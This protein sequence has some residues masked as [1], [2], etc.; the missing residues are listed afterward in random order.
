M[1]LRLR[2]HRARVEHRYKLM[3]LQI[4]HKNDI[5]I[6]RSVVVLLW[7]F[8]RRISDL[9]IWKYRLP[10]FKHR[11]RNW[12]LAFVFRLVDR[13]NQSA[14][15]WCI[16]L[17]EVFYILLDVHSI[18][19]KPSFPKQFFFPRPPDYHVVVN[20]ENRLE[21]FPIFFFYNTIYFWGSWRW[22]K[23]VCIICQ[24]ILM[25]ICFQHVCCLCIWI[26]FVTKLRIIKMNFKIPNTMLSHKED[27]QLIRVLTL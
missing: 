17:F 10:S 6:S 25:Q 19:G 27:Q 18:N 2:A 9:S 5:C 26:I 24:T 13:P 3:R 1:G 16:F 12:A 7:T 14:F 21:D 8:Q 20:I 15:V 4:A 22:S 23:I 11:R